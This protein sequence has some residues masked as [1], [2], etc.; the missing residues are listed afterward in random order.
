MKDPTGHIRQ[1][2]IAAPISSDTT[3]TFPT[4]FTNAASISVVG[5]FVWTT[6]DT[7][8]PTITSGSITTT[9]FTVHPNSDPGIPMNWI[10]D[11]Y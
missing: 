9:Q 10:A 1:W 7:A 2:G 5:I 11:G 8:Y 4:P 6:G 3:L